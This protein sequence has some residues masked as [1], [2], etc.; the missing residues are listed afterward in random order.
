[1]KPAVPGLTE[2][3][4]ANKKRVSEYRMGELMKTERVLEVNLSS[5]FAVLMYL[6]NSMVK[7][8]V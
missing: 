7:N 2:N 4:M 5:L 8:Q 3:N 1:V 6:C